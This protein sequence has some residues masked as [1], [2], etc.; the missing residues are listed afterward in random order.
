VII[1]RRT[2]WLENVTS[3]EMENAYNILAEKPGGNT[4]LE[5]IGVD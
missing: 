3:M 2:K 4:L 1:S 5:D